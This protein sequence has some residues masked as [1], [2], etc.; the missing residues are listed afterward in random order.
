MKPYDRDF[1]AGRH[2]GTVH[3]AR[4]ILS[5]LMERIPEIHSAVDVGCG[6]GTWL[7]VLREKGVE[8]IQGVDGDWVDP[9]MLEIPRERFLRIDLGVSAVKLPKRYDLAISL[10]VAEHLAPDRA[11]EFVSSLTALS[12]HV[13]FSAA[14][15]FQGGRNHVNEQWQH[16]WI[17]LFRA[18]DYEVHDFIRPGVWDDERIPFWYKQNLFLFSNRNKPVGNPADPAE[19]RPPPDAARSRA[20][21]P[22]PDE[23]PR[24][25]RRR[26]QLQDLPQGAEKLPE[27]KALARVAGP[28]GPR[29]SRLTF[30]YNHIYICLYERDGRTPSDFLADPSRLRILLLLGRKE[31]C[32]CQIMGVLDMSQPLVSRNLSAA[33]QGRAPGGP[34]GRQDDV[35]RLKKTLPEPLASLVKLLRNALGG[36]ETHE[37]D[38]Q[39]LGDCT[40]YQKKTGK[41]SMET[42]L[43]FM[44]R[45]KRSRKK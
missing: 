44:E 31:L 32:V 15:P 39:S 10:E 3:S 16:Y 9:E 38:L 40:E 4:T 25:R 28:P 1:Y 19:T 36:D 11:K 34:A 29:K 33:L 21:G 22:V 30:S 5:I 2:A 24:P 43:E 23:G 8:D 7:S 35:Y 37:R 14:V 18:V 13:L 12:D 27:G 45:K 42:F 41:C 6:I 20:P 26:K 17:E